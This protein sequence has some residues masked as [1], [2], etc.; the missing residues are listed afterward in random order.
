VAGFTHTGEDVVHEGKVITLVEARFTDPDGEAFTREVVRHPGAVAVVPLLD[1]GETVV[2]VRQFRAPIGEELLEIPAGKLDVGGEE[3]E[4]A[5]ARELEEEIG[6]RPGRLVRLARFFTSAG[7][8]DEHAEV[9]LGTDLTDS[10]VD[11]QGVEERHME[12]VE[13]RLADAPAMIAEG[14]LRDAKTIIGLQLAR[15]HLAG[16]SAA[17]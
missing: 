10:A 2:L 14:R 1:D 4:A 13:L 8:C 17:G 5:A 9:F 3:P 15:E 12:L 7:F 6:R 11:A 16:R